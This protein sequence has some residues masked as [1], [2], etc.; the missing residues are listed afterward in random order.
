LV[1]CC[2]PTLDYLWN[3]LSPGLVQPTRIRLRISLAALAKM[4]SVN[5]RPGEYRN[6]VSGKLA[7]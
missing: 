6:G 2:E 7:I 4:P 1:I 3:D 5:S